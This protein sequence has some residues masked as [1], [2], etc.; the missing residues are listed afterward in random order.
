MADFHTKSFFGQN[1]GIIIK[2][3]A[4]SVPYIFL[5]CINKKEDGTWEKP[6]KN[7]G[8]TIRLSL[9]EIICIL[10]VLN[11]KSQNWR[12]Y[13]VFKDE[14]TEI[15][16]GWHSEAREVLKFKIGNYKKKLKFPNT[17]FLI[18]LLEHILD[19][20]IEFATSGI[21]ETKV[22]REKKV[23]GEYSVFSEHIKAKDGLQVVETTEYELSKE[24]MEINVKIKIE[25]PKA[26][27]ISLD[28]GNEFWVPKSTVHS[29]YDV[30]N[31]ENYQKLL[32]DKWIIDKNI[33]QIFDKE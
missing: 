23:E 19:E 1:S 10:E 17:N 18:K 24:R 21:F 29:Q 2:S 15:F 31:K 3:P 16:V 33:Y 11:R 6:S 27:L 5:T 14:K 28:T 30:N 26:L 4:K 32:I 13:H 25:S 20:K 12:G 7:E 8:K 22:G 9:E